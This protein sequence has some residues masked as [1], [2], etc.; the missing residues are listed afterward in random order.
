LYMWLYKLKNSLSK[1]HHLACELLIWQ[2][3]ND[4]TCD[5]YWPI[6]MWMMY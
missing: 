6:L 5:S 4:M 1:Y 2:E 3:Y